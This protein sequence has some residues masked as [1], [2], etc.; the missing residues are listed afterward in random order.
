M[1]KLFGRRQRKEERDISESHL[2]TAARDEEEEGRKEDA[3]EKFF[4]PHLLP[5]PFQK[6]FPSPLL[7]SAAFKKSRE[8]S[9]SMGKRAGGGGCLCSSPPSLLHDTYDQVLFLKSIPAT[10]LG[11]RGRALFLFLLMYLLRQ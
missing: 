3:N 11:M 6:L 1:M 8:K 9:L 2:P 4:L 7:A 5:P 10:L